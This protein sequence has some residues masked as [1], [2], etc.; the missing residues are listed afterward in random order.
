MKTWT[1]EDKT[2]LKEHY[3]IMPTEDI[4]KYLDS[5][6]SQIY[7]Q[8]SYLRKRGWTFHTRRDISVGLPTWDNN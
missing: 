6:A 2:F 4:M 5:S 1:D 3:N 8:V 7:S